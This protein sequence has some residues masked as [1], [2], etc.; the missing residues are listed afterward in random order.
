[1]H[2]NRGQRDEHLAPY[3]GTIDWAGALL[4]LQKIGYDGTMMLELA[5]A[6]PSAPAL[7]RARQA[8]ARLED[9]AGSWT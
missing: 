9:A 1:M 8:V 7:E 4:A 5:S 6:E 2:D 3:E